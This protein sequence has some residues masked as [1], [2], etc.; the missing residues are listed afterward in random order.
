MSWWKGPLVGFDLETTGTDP[1][2]ARIV[3]AALVD[4]IGGKV[5]RS[6]DW[7][8]D[9]GVPIPSEA[10]AIHGV[11][12]ERARREGRSAAEA[13]A[14]I[15]TALGERLAEGRPVVLFNA[16]FDLTLLDVELRRYGQPGLAE[17]CGGAVRPVVDALVIDRSV[18]RYRKGSRTLQRVC[19]LYGIDLADA[20]HAASDAL[21]AVR[22]A[23]ALGERYPALVGD[24]TTAALHERQISWYQEWAE[25][26]QSWLRRDK[27][28]EAVV[29]PSWPLR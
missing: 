2:E 8:I 6:L 25:G 18:D 7:L 1:A 17:C 4:T 15:A 20:H 26:L 12:D 24:V 23:V 28:A 22:V 27:D 3:T 5:E 16:P 9:P 19:S 10:S 14:E 21:A 29:D 11:T 13:V